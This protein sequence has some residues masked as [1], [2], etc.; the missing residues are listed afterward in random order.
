MTT[1]PAR[2]V[3]D[4]RPVSPEHRERG[5]ALMQAWAE[6]DADE[7]HAVLHDGWVD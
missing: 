1:S 5:E 7:R 6:L 2:D 4:G 3:H